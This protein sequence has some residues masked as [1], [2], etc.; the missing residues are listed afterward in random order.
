MGSLLKR[1]LPGHGRLALVLMV[2][3]LLGLL[4]TQ[5]CTTTVQGGL[6]VGDPAPAFTL[7]DLDGN[8]VSLSDFQGKTVFVNFWATWCGPCRAEMPAIEAVYQEYKD[9]DV[10]VIGMDVFEPEDDVRQYVQE[11]GYSWTFVIDTTGEVTTSY[12]V[13]AIPTSFFIDGKGIIQAMNIGAMSKGAME[14]KLAFAM[15]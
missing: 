11:G 5:G 14:V 4:T 10:V 15:R 1:N 13:T 2:I 9:K 12:K 6:G 7:V 8:Q 3:A